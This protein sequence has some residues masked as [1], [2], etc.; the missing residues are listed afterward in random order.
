MSAPAKRDDSELGRA[1]RA[2]GEQVLKLRARATLAPDL[3][4][5]Y[6]KAERYHAE[7]VAVFE[8]A[9]SG[10][11]GVGLAAGLELLERLPD[12][13]AGGWTTSSLRFR[14]GRSPSE[15]LDRIATL[16]IPDGAWVEA[17]SCTA[18]DCSVVLSA[19]NKEL[20]PRRVTAREPPTL[21]PKPWW[22]S[23]AN[24]WE[25]ARET[26]DEVIRLQEEVADVD[27]KASVYHQAEALESVRLALRSEPFRA[28]L[29]QLLRVLEGA[30]VS[31]FAVDR[32]ETG[33]EITVRGAPELKEPLGRLG[34]PEV[35]RVSDTG[36]TYRLRRRRDER[37]LRFVVPGEMPPGASVLAP[38]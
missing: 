9:V 7:Q 4:E 8:R 24:R 5:R 23:R 2:L 36:M 28:E 25:R 22:P 31:G 15:L 20:A 38:G 33:F 3:R 18:L 30:G 16:N 37:S 17:A 34:L 35:A 12:R 26:R 6:G 14:A 32:V 21:P 19:A 29:I 13:R 11:E 10:L 27:A 1:E